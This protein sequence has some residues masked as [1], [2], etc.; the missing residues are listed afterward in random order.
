MQEAF[1]DKHDK[2]EYVIQEMQALVKENMEL[3]EKLGAA[4]VGGGCNVEA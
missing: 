4:G 1:K 2:A 3:V